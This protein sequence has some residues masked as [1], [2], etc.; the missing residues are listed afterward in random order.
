MSLRCSPFIG[1][2][3][4]YL[5]LPSSFRFRFREKHITDGQK[6]EHYAVCGRAF[7]SFLPFPSLF[8]QT[9]VQHA[10]SQSI[11]S[12]TTLRSIEQGGFCRCEICD[13]LLSSPLYSRCATWPVPADRQLCL[14]TS[15]HGRCRYAVTDEL[16][17]VT[18][19]NQSAYA[20]VDSDDIYDVRVTSGCHRTLHYRPH[21]K[22][23]DVC[24]K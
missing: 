7:L 19:Y 24:R 12:W 22:A 10:I 17:P 20:T 3:F 11:M 1:D 4:V 15:Q 23:E 9:I 5:G 21:M 8:A 16:L 18:T 2:L 6:Y 14:M 13:I